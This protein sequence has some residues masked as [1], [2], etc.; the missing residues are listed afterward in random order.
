VAGKKAYVALLRAVNVGGT[1]KL[2][3]KELKAMCEEAG[4]ESVSTY[5]QSG[6]VVFRTDDDEDKVKEII[7]RR[8]AD[9]FGQKV[10]VFVRSAREMRDI[11][12]ANP[13]PE[14]PGNRVAVLFLDRKPPAKLAELARGVRNETFEPAAREVFIHYPEGLGRSRLSFGD[15]LV[16]TVRNMNTVTR[17][18]EMA[19]G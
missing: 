5:I 16:G 7:E 17:L 8:L 19:S 18:A 3:M 15:D 11:V 1:G 9:H 10:D 14:E 12:D 6:N 13:Y 4:F 2:P